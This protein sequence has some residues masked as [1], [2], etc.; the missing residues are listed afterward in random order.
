MSCIRS[1]GCVLWQGKLVPLVSQP[2][3]L[4]LDCERYDR[5]KRHDFFVNKLKIFSLYFNLKTRYLC[6]Y[7]EVYAIFLRLFSVPQRV[8]DLYR[9]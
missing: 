2:G 7:L 5:Q 1:V 4:A 3:S 8:S 6:D 9:R